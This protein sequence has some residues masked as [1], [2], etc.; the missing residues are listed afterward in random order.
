M[1]DDNGV[2]LIFLLIVVVDLGI[3]GS[4]AVGVV[5]R[6]PFNLSGFIV[7]RV[8]GIVLRVPQIL[9]GLG[10]RRRPPRRSCSC[11]RWR[12]EATT[13]PGR[14]CPTHCGSGIV[15]GRRSLLL[16]SPRRILLLLSPRG[17]NNGGLRSP[18][19][20]HNGGLLSAR[21]INN[22]RRLSTAIWVG[23]GDYRGKRAGPSKG[24]QKKSRAKHGIS[25]KKTGRSTTLSAA[26]E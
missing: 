3:G 23:H 19:R 1:V 7:I 16:L 13:R 6:H 22:G 17:V 8:L 5:R 24:R 25:E 11:N 4:W 26:T 10:R 20:V 12:R 14:V 9:F 2:A 18:G 21:G 15:R